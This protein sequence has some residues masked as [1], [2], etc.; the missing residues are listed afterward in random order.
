MRA[1]MA[2]SI[3]SVIPPI[4]KVDSVGTFPGDTMLERIPFGPSSVAMVTDNA[5]MPAFA[6]PYALKF[7]AAFKA[8]MEEIPIRHEPGFM[9]AEHARDA[10]K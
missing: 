3:S 10:M 8:A 5:F 9:I 7:T 2:G 6:E 4:L 1:A